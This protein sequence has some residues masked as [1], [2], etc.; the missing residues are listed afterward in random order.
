LK[1]DGSVDCWGDDYHGQAT[2]S[3]GAFLSV[4]AGETHTCGLKVDGSVDCWGYDYYGQYPTPTGAFLSAS[5]GRY[6]TCGLKADGSVRCWGANANGQTTVP[7]SLAAAGSTAFGQI[8]A[9]NAHACDLKRDGSIRCWGDNT[10]GQAAPPLGEFTQVVAG[11]VL[12]CAIG[13][14]GKVACWGRDGATITGLADVMAGMWRQLAPAP[15]GAVCML[16]SL[17]SEVRCQR[18]G[19][20]SMSSA[21]DFRNITHGPNF[22]SFPTA[23]GVGA[24]GGAGSCVFGGFASIPAGP[25]QRLESGLSHQC[26]LKTDGTLACWGDNTEGQTDNLPSGQFRTFSVGYNHACAIRGDGTLACWG[27]NVSGQTDPPAGTYVQVAAGNTFSCAIRSDGQRACWGGA[28]GNPATL[29]ALPNGVSGTAYS[30]QISISGPSAPTNPVFVPMS[31]ALPPGLSISASGLVSGTPTTVGTFTFTIDAEGTG[32][33]A[34]TRT[35]SVTISDGT[36]PVI[37]YAFDPPAPDGSNGWYVGDVDVDWTVTDPESAISST[38]CN[39]T[40]LSSDTAGASWT[41]SAASTGGSNSVTTAIVKRD[42]TPPTITTAATT[43]PD[44]NNGW[45]VSPVTVSFTCNDALSGIASCP[46]DQVLNSDGNPVSSTAQTAT[47]NAGN[48]SAPSN[49]VAVKIDRTPPTLAPSV[50]SPI[51]VGQSASASPNASDATSGIASSSCGPLDTSSRGD[52]ST[53][54]SA[55]D[56]AGNSRTVQLDYTVSTTCANDGYKGTQL[57]W[58]RNICE[59]GLT[60]AT[61]DTWIH[62]WIQRYRDLPYCRVVPAN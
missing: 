14:G 6:H 50:P 4:S 11:D 32:D 24:S 52:F 5:V 7:A 61:L 12:T 48:A 30:R 2:P 1:A 3:T 62:R 39:D 17:T 53:T 35:Y 43:A 22:E 36:P 15:D 29:S 23:C 59:N 46:A 49:V 19:F 9:G 31:G 56:N 34:A 44:G 33:F 27:S 26:G 16:S 21:S 58:C 37:G 41:C 28:P 60:G 47:D 20:G 55:T 18:P 10:S 54:C 45:Y 40:T 38:G 42:A 25:W 8:A 13:A 57:T 51:L